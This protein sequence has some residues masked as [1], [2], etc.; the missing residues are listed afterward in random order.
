MN[1]LNR[2]KDFSIYTRILIHVLFTLRNLQN[3]FVTKYHK[4]SISFFNEEGDV[5]VVQI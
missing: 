1:I 4:K 2:Y 3:A 5:Q